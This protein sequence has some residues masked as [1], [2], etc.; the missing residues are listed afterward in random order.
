VCP[1]QCPVPRY[2]LFHV[3]THNF[4]FQ[5]TLHPALRIIFFPV[6]VM[7]ELVKK[8]TRFWNYVRLNAFPSVDVNGGV[9]CFCLAYIVVPLL[10]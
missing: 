3:C 4:L 5:K 7:L 2:R 6:K 10:L 1:L 9:C 8:V